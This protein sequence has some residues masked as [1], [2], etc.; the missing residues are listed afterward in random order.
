MKSLKF[1]KN[2]KY[3][4]L[5]VECISNRKG[6]KENRLVHLSLV[7]ERKFEWEDGYQKKFKRNLTKDNTI[8]FQGSKY[9]LSDIYGMEHVWE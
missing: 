6:D 9:D 1:D 3:G 4:S 5:S 7:N 8:K 2:G